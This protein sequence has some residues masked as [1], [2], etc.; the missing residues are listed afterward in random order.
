MAAF[1]RILSGNPGLDEAL[2]NIR[3]G[4]NVVF[5]VSE[6]KEFRFF[7]EPYVEQAIADKRNLIY[8]RFAAHEPLIEE[9]EGVKIYNIPLSHLFE[10]FTVDIHNI[11]EKE[12]RDAFYVFDCL[13]ELQTAWATD[14]MMGNFF[15]VTCPFLFILDTV[16]FF[17]IIRGKHSVSA[18]N[19]IKDTT[20]LFLDVY[21][22]DGRVFLRPAKVWNRDSETMFLPHICTENGEVRPVQDG[23]MS[24]R[25]YSVLRKKSRPGEEQFTDSWDR[26]FNEAKVLYESGNDLEETSEKMCRIMMTRDERLQV[27]LRKHFSPEDYFDTRSHMVGTGM[28]GGKACGML[29]ARAII[30]NKAPEIDSV[31]EEHDS[32]F[33]GSDMFYT[34]I[35]DNGF[36][37]LKIRQ[38]SDEEY[39]S[40]AEEF[41]ESIMGGVFSEDMEAQFVNILEYYGHDPFIVRSSSILEDGFGNAFAGKYESVFCVNRG[42]LSDRLKE[43]E[44]AIRTVYASTMSLS[45][46][47]YRK[48]RGLDK[49]DEQMALLVQ[50]ISGSYYGQFF[51]PCA[52]GVAYSYSPY[53]FLRS[54]DQTAGML[55]LVMGLG[56]SAVDRIDG[57][58]PR[59]VSLD[60]PEA[61]NYTTVA[62]KHRFSQRKAEAIDTA[63]RCLNLVD[64]DTILENLPRYLKNILSERDMEAENSLKSM[65]RSG[66]VRF[67]SC[68]GIVSNRE[69]M[70]RMREML[71]AVS[72][73]YE[74]AVDV[75]FTINTAPDGEYAINLLQCRPLKVYKDEAEIRIPE[76][77][78][79]DKILV[80]SRHSSMGL[81]RKEA[82]DLVVYVDPVKYYNLPYSEKPAAAKLIGK[83]NWK[84]RNSGKKLVLMVPG[85]ICT[86]S[87]EL[88][89]P[90]SFS[91][92]SGFEAVFEIEERTAGY[93]PELSY[94]S[95]IF[96]DLVEQEILYSA[97]FTSDNETVFSPE[98]LYASEDISRQFEA[99]SSL[100]DVVRVFDTSSAGL[101]LYYDMTEEHLLLV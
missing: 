13:S 24:S 11:I 14:L 10:T 56:T 18:I 19:K 15:K 12:G 96:Q 1:D 82:V 30:R 47:D 65:G 2:D 50:R 53:K 100:C 36:W 78:D 90:A 87:P 73:E 26:F 16:A 57:S 67:V 28:I 89:I 58:Y 49:K 43:F 52:A 70:N 81:S 85:R 75:E 98:R 48:R 99:E 4:D 22:E 6:L 39:F 37:D 41:A 72:S 44:D 62:E 51:M 29:L 8:F 97:V 91:D 25:F 38:R 61:T 34:Y 63:G 83:I 94:G 5:R 23:V 95:H 79:K 84:Y 76:E 17:P 68:K 32:F 20:Q 3:L 35:V 55:R 93:N 71:Q 40:L 7:M 33:I 60:N 92:I 42:E 64:S 46:L 101:M 9:R 69:M 66:E 45:A 59:L 80:E 31:M 21:S 77:T 86:S 27:L 88:G 74:H 54:I